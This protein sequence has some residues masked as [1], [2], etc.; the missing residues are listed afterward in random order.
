MAL[1][2]AV[3]SA[4][5]MNR[6]TGDP[7]CGFSSPLSAPQTAMLQALADAVAAAVVSHIQTAAVVAV[8]SVSG[9][10]TGVGVSGPGAGT[11]S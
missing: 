8:T 6:W 3:L 1:N 7:N 2:A 11:I 5:I 4:D 10:T 9:V